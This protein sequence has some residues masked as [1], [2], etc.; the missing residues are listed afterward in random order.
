MKKILLIAVLILLI[1]C[2]LDTFNSDNLASW[3]INFDFPLFKTN[4]T[5]RELLDDQDGLDIEL[6]E[7]GPDS[8]YVFNNVTSHTIDVTFNIEKD[9]DDVLPEVIPVEPYAI[10]IATLPEELD[11]INFVDID[12]FL[13]IDLTQFDTSLADSVIIDHITLTG[14]NDDG[15]VETA[16]ITN[17]DILVVGMVEVEDPED[18]VNIRPTEVT[19]DGQITVYPSDKEEPFIGEKIILNSILHAPLILEVTE[20]AT[21]SGNPEKI[22][23]IVD[24]D[25]FEELYLYVDVRNGLELGG[26]LQLLVA[27]D[28]LM[29]EENYFISPDTLFTLDLIPEDEFIDTIRIDDDKLALLADSTYLKTNLNFIGPTDAQ[30]NIRPTRLFADDSISILIY[31]SAQLLIDPQNGE[32]D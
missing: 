16:T 24:E 25:L 29:F 6:Y 9:D 32:E 19:L 11:G 2:S 8:I 18:L 22:D 3:S 15:V 26:N 13:E 7:N 28:T 5:I 31:S 30:D 4:Y 14:V 27:P 1:A 20:A 21:F 10:E 23:G 12:L 17:Q